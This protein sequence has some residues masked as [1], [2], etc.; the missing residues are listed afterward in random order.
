MVG[1]ELRDASVLAVAVDEDGRV[2]ARAEVAHGG[3]RA[4]ADAASERG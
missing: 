4:L 3:A 1:V 2:A